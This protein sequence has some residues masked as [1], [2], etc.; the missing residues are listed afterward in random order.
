MGCATRCAGLTVA[1]AVAT[2]GCGS[3]TPRPSGSAVT[4]GAVRTAFAA[5]GLPLTGLTWHHFGPVKR[6]QY[7]YWS[8]RGAVTTTPSASVSVRAPFDFTVLVFKTTAQAR[9]ALAATRSYLQRARTPAIRR[10]NLILA[11]RVPVQPATAGTW[12]RA[13][14]ALRTTS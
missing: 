6:V 3:S 7:L 2:A 1:F 12:A 14:A 4:V 8:R 5:K 9:S 10:G 11:A 13:E